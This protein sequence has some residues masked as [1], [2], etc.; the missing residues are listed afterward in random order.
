[1]NKRL[2]EKMEKKYSGWEANCHI[3]GNRPTQVRCNKIF[4][5]GQFIG[6]NIIAVPLRGTIGNIQIWDRALSNEEM[7]QV[8]ETN[9][10]EIASRANQENDVAI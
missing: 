8:Y 6:F 7:N 3:I 5:R 2:R 9:K 1:M 10:S 4:R